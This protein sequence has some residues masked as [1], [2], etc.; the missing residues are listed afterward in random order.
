M[1]Y[2]LITGATSG[3]GRALAEE[4][5]K[6]GQNLL[7]ASRNL[8]K[9]Q[10]LQKYFTEKYRIEVIYNAIDLS[11][12]QAPEELYAFC[13]KNAY[14]IN[15]LVNNAGI[16]LETKRQTEQDMA[17]IEKLFQLNINAVLKLSTL[18]G[19]DMQIRQH[20]YILN[21]ASTAAFQ[22]M[23]YAALYGAAKAFV[24]SLS[25][26]MH[27][28]LKKFGIGVTAVC[29]GITDTN[30]FKHGRPTVPSWIYKLV[31][32]ELVARRAVKALY[33]K[34]IYIVPY[35]QHWIIAQLS[36]FLPRQIMADLMYY[37]ERLRKKIP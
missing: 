35:F 37:I 32:P 26:A 2:T 21:V 20:G 29:P 10:E 36:R 34:K 19:Q 30:F 1:E 15:I 24:L 27:I 33:K 18:F 22:P 23:P 6:R 28:E 13:Q 17:E 16:G 5:A 12:P 11:D 25:E 9:M 3:I 4:F 14:T 31:S 8:T 7:L